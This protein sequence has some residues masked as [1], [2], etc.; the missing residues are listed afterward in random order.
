MLT[1][2]DADRTLA[3]ELGLYLVQL[4][5]TDE[6]RALVADP[7]AIRTPQNWQVKSVLDHKPVG[8]IYFTSVDSLYATKYAAGISGIE[9][10]VADALRWM[11]RLRHV[12]TGEYDGTEIARPGS[13]LERAR[14]ITECNAMA[15]SAD[16]NKTSAE[17]ALINGQA[18]EVC[19]ACLVK[20]EASGIRNLSKVSERQG[21]V[22]PKQRDFIHRLLEEAARFG[23][24]HC[25]E[26]D[27]MS[28]RSASAMID[29]LKALKARDWKGTL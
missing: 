10:T 1:I 5:E 28:S 23:R 19:P 11:T 13:V 15:T 16:F 25:M 8:R 2:S 7:R 4:P 21:S 24:Q 18:H 20:I 22:T 3:A 9:E 14:A 6:D 12:R 29:A 26:V 27:Q 17:S